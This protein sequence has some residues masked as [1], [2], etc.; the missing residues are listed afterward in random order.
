MNVLSKSLQTILN[1]RIWRDGRNSQKEIF[2][3]SRY[4][5]VAEDIHSGMRLFFCF[6]VRRVWTR[7]V[8]ASSNVVRVIAARPVSDHEPILRETPPERFVRAPSLRE[9]L[10][11]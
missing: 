8:H 4:V 7:W 6:V 10:R 1:V 11:P 9:L 3:E 5:F 2:D